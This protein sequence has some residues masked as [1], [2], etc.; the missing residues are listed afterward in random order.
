VLERVVKR[1]REAG[2]GFSIS[3]LSDEVLGALQKNQLYELIGEENVYPTQ[4]VAI[5]SIHAEAHESSKERE[6]PLLHVVPQK[7][8]TED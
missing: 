4:A 8:T 7:L 1:L 5:E 6:C 3:G 2:Y